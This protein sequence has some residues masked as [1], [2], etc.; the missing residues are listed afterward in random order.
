M[1]FKCF[2]TTLDSIMYRGKCKILVDILGKVN[3]IV[4]RMKQILF[5]VLASLKL[6]YNILQMICVGLKHQEA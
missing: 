1:A 5:H 4:L 3:C 6:A 2:R